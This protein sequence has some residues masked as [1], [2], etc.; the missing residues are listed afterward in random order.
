MKTADKT[1]GTF[2]RKDRRRRKPSSEVS[3]DEVSRWRL[4]NGDMNGR[5]AYRDSF[6]FIKQSR[7]D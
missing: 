2:W 6:R 3:R 5:I 7:L 4:Q 1:F